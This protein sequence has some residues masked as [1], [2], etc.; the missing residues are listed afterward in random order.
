[1]TIESSNNSICHTS[2]LYELITLNFGFSFY[3][4]NT[5]NIWAHKSSLTPPLLIEMPVPIQESQ[6]FFPFLLFRYLILELARHCGIFCFSFYLKIRFLFLTY[7]SKLNCPSR[8]TVKSW[9]TVWWLIVKNCTI[10]RI[11]RR[12][13]HLYELAFISPIFNINAWL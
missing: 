7:C 4:D 10:P 9:S 1:M 12:G 11:V 5:V 2:S 3:N 13:D 6:R 8:T